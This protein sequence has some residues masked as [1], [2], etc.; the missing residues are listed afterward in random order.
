V[1][2]FA[3]IVNVAIT[4]PCAESEMFVPLILPAS[5][6][7]VIGALAGGHGGA[8][9]KVIVTVTVVPRLAR[10]PGATEPV[11]NVVVP[12]LSKFAMEVRPTR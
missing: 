8:V 7:L 12:A 2:T 1:E 10:P 4:V 11:E 3:G 6:T 5:V 9:G